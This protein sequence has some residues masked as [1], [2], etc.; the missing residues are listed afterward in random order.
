MSNTTSIN[1]SKRRPRL[2]DAEYCL[3]V[4]E[5]YL[6]MCRLVFRRQREKL[7]HQT[8]SLYNPHVEKFEELRVKSQRSRKELLVV[9]M[10]LDWVH[11]ELE[12][13]SE[14]ESTYIKL[15]EDQYWKD[16]KGKRFKEPFHFILTVPVSQWERYKTD[17][18]P[19]PRFLSSLMAPIREQSRQQKFFRLLRRLTNRP[20]KPQRVRGYRDRGHLA[21]EA[22]LAIT[23]AQLAYNAE[24]LLLERAKQYK[25]LSLRESRFGWEERYGRRLCRELSL[26]YQYWPEAIKIVK[27]LNRR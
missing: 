22:S 11:L 13:L 10:F 4:L 20:Q 16:I 6:G 15:L 8:T 5:Q 7:L 9:K 21:S 18:L 19:K 17:Y 27:E 23:K 25:A 2:E 12:R 24:K 26:P 3:V 14:V 1:P